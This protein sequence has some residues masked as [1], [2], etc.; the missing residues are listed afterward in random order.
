MNYS[1]FYKRVLGAVLLGLCLAVSLAAQQPATGTGAKALFYDPATG[2]VLKPEEKRRDAQNG[3]TKVKY[4][5]PAQAKY[6][7]IHYWLD[8]ED[9]GPVT[10]ERVFHTGDRI[11]IHIRSNVDGYLSLWSL[12]SSGRGHLLFPVSDQTDADNAIKADSDFST[13]GFITFR[14]PAEDE[15]LLVFFSRSKADMPT[16]T[17]NGQN[18]GGDTVAKV[19]RHTG[20]KA[21]V[22]E[23]EK[24][25]PDETGTYV[26]NRTGGAVAREIHLKHQSNDSKN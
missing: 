3:R 13:P 5:E 16:R 25:D 14:P 21:L 11:K 6:V 4:T 1:R 18:D 9:V 7:G 12:D 19:L 15:R 2:R 23:T 20:S 17:N 22:F 26:V 10:D 24:K 8:L